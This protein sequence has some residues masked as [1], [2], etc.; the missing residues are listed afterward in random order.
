[1]PIGLQ[2]R[3]GLATLSCGLFYH[4]WLGVGI[5][6]VGSI[7]GGVM[8]V[9]ASLDAMPWMVWTLLVG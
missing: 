1:M 5:M 9:E 7:I 6:R 8:V 3:W 4:S 2:W